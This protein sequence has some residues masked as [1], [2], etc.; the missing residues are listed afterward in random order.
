MPFLC[1]MRA[2]GA[3]LIGVLWSGAT[4]IGVDAAEEPSQFVKTLGERA[5]NI[6]TSEG[7]TPEG[8]KAQFRDLL[9]EGFAVNT[10]GR[11][12]LGRYWRAATPEELN[13]Y[14]VL[15]R[16]FVLD[17]YSQ[18][19]DS[20]AGETF[21]II[22]SQPLDEQDTMV[23]TEIGGT[24][25]PAIRVDYRVRSQ[26][27]IH[28]IVDVLVEGVSLVVTQRAEFASVINR[29]GFDGLIEILR[30]YGSKDTASN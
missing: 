9:D 21:E 23:S 29:E 24:D 14:L 27:G 8:R 30:R 15:F 11:F 2:I 17:T 16:D 6:L 20:Y 10:I 28:K 22:K 7:T 1:R 5:I 26:A 12:V 4:C 18:R 19:L 13:E 3:V 25:G